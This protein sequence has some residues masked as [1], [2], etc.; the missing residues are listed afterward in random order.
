MI[1]DS[2]PVLSFCPEHELPGSSGLPLGEVFPAPILFPVALTLHSQNTAAA[3]RL[4]SLSSIAPY[5]GLRHTLL[6]AQPFLKSV[7]HVVMFLNFY[8]TSQLSSH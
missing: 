7:V 1:S 6:P 4:A 2:H 8:H 3:A 5:L